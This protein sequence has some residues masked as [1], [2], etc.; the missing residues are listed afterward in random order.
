MPIPFLDNFLV[1]GSSCGCCSSSGHRYVIDTDVKNPDW[2]DACNTNKLVGIRMLHAQDPDLINEPVDDTGHKAIHL[3]IQNKNSEMLQYVLKNGANIN[4]RGGKYGN[5]ALHEAVILRD[6]KA[7]R[8]LFSFGIDDTITN[9]HGKRAIDLCPKSLRRE[10]TKAKTYRNKYR[11]QLN[12]MQHTRKVTNDITIAGMSLKTNT[13]EIKKYVKDTN[14]EL[15]FYRNK[16]KEIEEREMPQT[17]FGDDV[18]CDVDEI[19]MTLQ[20]VPNPAKLWQKWAKKQSLTRQTEIYKILYGLTVLTLK[21]KNPRSR[22]PP[23]QPLKLLTSRF[24]KQLPKN[25]G[26]RTL[27][28]QHFTKGCHNLLYQ[29]HEEM[30]NE[31]LHIASLNH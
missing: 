6:M 9:I 23:S 27:T 11:Q 24:C 25:K 8:H 16:K 31:E 26:K 2:A 29:L 1:M 5:T 13:K 28:R 30:V 14:H 20:R 22:K 4:A 12:E 21:K 15:N 19:A 17:T 7:V 3:S 10:F 18:G